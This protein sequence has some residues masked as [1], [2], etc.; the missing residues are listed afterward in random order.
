VD[1]SKSVT[2]TIQLHQ[3]DTVWPAIVRNCPTPRI[4]VKI[5]TQGHDA[6]VFRG[7]ADHLEHVVGVQTEL[8]AIELYDG[9]T[10]MADALKLYDSHGYAPIG[11]FPVTYLG[12]FGVVTEFDVILKRFSVETVG[13][14][15]RLAESQA[16]VL[17]GRPM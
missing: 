12:D 11:F 9:M 5:D 8:P 13:S 7:A 16:D 17:P 15:A 3:I 10:P 1:A 4:L 6:A 14:V 2:E